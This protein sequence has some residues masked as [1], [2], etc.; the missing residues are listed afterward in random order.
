VSLSV[1]AA[2]LVVVNLGE[3]VTCEPELGAGPLGVIPPCGVNHVRRVIKRGRAVWE[4]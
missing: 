3:L 2:D 4:R 1:P